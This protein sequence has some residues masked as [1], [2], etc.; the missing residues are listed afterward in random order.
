MMIQCGVNWACAERGALYMLFMNTI[1]YY[2]IAILIFGIF[3]YAGKKAF[4][5]YRI[6]QSEPKKGRIRAEILNSFITLFIFS[7][8][9]ISSIMLGQ[10]GLTKVYRDFNAYPLWYLPVSFILL[11]AWH[12]TYFYWAHRLMHTK[13]LYRLIHLTHHRSINPSPFAGYSF[14]PIES[15]LEGIYLVMFVMVFPVNFVVVLIHTFYAMIINI[16]VH[17]GIEL[18]PSGFTTGR[19][20]KWINTSTHHNMHHSHT[21]GNY[22]LYFNFWD[23][24][25]GTNHPKYTETFEAVRARVKAEKDGAS[26]SGKIGAANEENPGWSANR[27]IVTSE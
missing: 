9:G 17:T 2:P 15:V 22:A 16:W 20:T 12:E 21:H 7:L 14:H 3:W 11:T 27:E 13:L 1:R 18:F 8:I 5:K 24:I 4:W 26:K 23:R 19:I 25:M 6:Q 10:L